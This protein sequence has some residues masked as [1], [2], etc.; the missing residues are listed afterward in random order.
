MEALSFISAISL[1]LMAPV[2]GVQ[3]QDAAP[4]PEVK[5]M[6]YQQWTLRCVTNEA[7]K[8]C[9]INQFVLLRTQENDT[10][11]PLMRVTFGRDSA[12]TETLLLMLPLGT[13]L[14]KGISFNVSEVMTLEDLNVSFC[15]TGG[16][17]LLYPVN[18]GLL[19]EMR[20]GGQGNVNLYYLNAPNVLSLPVDFTGFN[21][22]YTAF[23]AEN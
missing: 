10:T 9:E 23:L 15:V 2:P 20:A 7:G 14:V 21:E 1:A 22:A 3:A 4:E 13:N 11:Q 16:C 17:R 12:G 6:N 8:Q 18:S 19:A 5:T